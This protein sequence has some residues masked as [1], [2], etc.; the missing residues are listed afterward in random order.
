MWVC[1]LV[2]RHILKAVNINDVLTVDKKTNVLF[3]GKEIITEEEKKLLHAEAVEF[4]K[5]RLYSILLNTP[6]H[7]AQDILF[8][9]LTSTDDFWASKMM[10]YNIDVQ[11][12]IIE[13][14]ESLK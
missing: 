1:N 7:H 5:T 3:L 14:L 2:T 11:E 8:K 10:L 6:A 12:K 4:K 13:R 9:K